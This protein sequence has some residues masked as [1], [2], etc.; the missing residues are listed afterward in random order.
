MIGGVNMG[1]SE[2]LEEKVQVAQKEIRHN[3]R[4]LRVKIIKRFNEDKRVTLKE[5][6][7]FAKKN[8]VSVETL[9]MMIFDI[10]NEFLYRRKEKSN[11]DDN[12]LKK[13]IK[14]E[15]EHTTNKE[16]AKIIAIDHL[17]QIPNYYTLL[18]KFDKD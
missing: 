1:F 4:E 7:Q 2:Y 17:K 6:E 13:G 12:E 15:L 5:L 16:L 11:I 9:Y 8:Q 3:K 10:L 14:H 18:S